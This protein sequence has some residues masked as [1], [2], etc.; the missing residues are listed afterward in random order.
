APLLLHPSALPP[1]LR[2]FPTRRSSDLEAVPGAEPV[3]DLDQVGGDHHVLVGGLAEHTL[4]ALLDDRDL[5][6]GLEQGIGRA[7]R[8]GLADG[9]LALLLVAYRHG[10]VLQRLAIL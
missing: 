1:D 4:G 6:A 7:L 3:D 5:D 8:L 2:S 9:D 10:G